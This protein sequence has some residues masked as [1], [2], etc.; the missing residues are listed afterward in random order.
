MAPK[1]KIEIEESFNNSTAT[2]MAP[3]VIVKIEESTNNSKAIPEKSSSHISSARLE[4]EPHLADIL[5]KVFA[6]KKIFF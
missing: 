4:L 2:S 5:R 3:K 6:E 1:A